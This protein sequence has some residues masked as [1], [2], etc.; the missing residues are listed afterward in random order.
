MRCKCRIRAAI[1]AGDTVT[2][3]VSGSQGIGASVMAA[4]AS[5]YQGAYTVTPSEDAQT[6]QTAGMNLVQNIVVEP[7]PS[8]YGLITYNGSVITVS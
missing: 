8:N 3:R 2:G 5:P 6:I 1:R 7:I 4:V